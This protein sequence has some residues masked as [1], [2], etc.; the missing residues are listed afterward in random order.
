MRT[1]PMRTIWVSVKIWQIKYFTP[2]KYLLVI[3]VNGNPVK[4]IEVG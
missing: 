1:V 3:V 2:D 4:A